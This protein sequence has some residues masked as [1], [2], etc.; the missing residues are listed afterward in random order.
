[1]KYTNYIHPNTKIILTESIEHK[2]P[3]DPSLPIDTLNRLRELGY[4][5]YESSFFDDLVE[6]SL[7]SVF[8]IHGTWRGVLA[9]TPKYWD[10][11]EEVLD[12]PLEDLP[13]HLVGPGTKHIGKDFKAYKIA[14]HVARKRLELGI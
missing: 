11:V 14:A 13:L 10:I 5:F 2:F 6:K 8:V 9:N 12:C 4:D 1:M 3:G 7:I